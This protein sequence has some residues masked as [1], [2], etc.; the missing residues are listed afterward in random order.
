MICAFSEETLSGSGLSI[1]FLGV[2][3]EKWVICIGNKLL[4]INLFV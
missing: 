4:E 2:L 3:A 1:D